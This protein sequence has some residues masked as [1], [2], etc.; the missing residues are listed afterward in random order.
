MSRK[1]ISENNTDEKDFEFF[2]QEC[3]KW[4]DL[5]SLHD[6][7]F[8]FLH[9]D[10]ESTEGYILAMTNLVF[11][12]SRTAAISLSKQWGTVLVTKEMLSESAQDEIL[13][14]VL[15]ELMRYAKDNPKIRSIEH[16]V[17]HRIIYM[18]KKLREDL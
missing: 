16:G 18:T 10:Q 4:A 13:H 9:E 1:T 6:W 8:T 5:F 14:V 17:I 11:D 3:L 15:A 12:G 7:S 2:K